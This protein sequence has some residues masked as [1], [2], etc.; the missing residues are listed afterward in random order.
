MG[1]R[2]R[3]KAGQKDTCPHQPT[4]NREKMLQSA[5]WEGTREALEVLMY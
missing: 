2:A 4:D 5:V 1:I 3:G